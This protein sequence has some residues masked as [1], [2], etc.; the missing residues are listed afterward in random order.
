[1][2]Q[3]KAR[4]AKILEI[5]SA[6]EIENQQELCKALY[7]NGVLTAQATVSR[8]INELHL[9]KVLGEKKRYKY[10]Y[11]GGGQAGLS[12]KMR[13]LFKE[14]VSSIKRANNIVVIRTISGGGS[15]V[16]SVV[17]KLVYPEILGCVAGDDTVIVVCATDQCASE[18]VKQLEDLF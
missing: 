7:E 12:P 4:H 3:K 16:G 14:S 9:V 2:I 15:G 1:M 10:V 18:V 13:N 5:I 8:D 17:D 6:Q 11:I